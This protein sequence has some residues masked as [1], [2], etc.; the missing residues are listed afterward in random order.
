MPMCPCGP[1]TVAL[2]E[3][4]TSQALLCPLAGDREAEEREA[5]VGAEAALGRDE[6][7]LWGSPLPPL[8]EP[9]CRLPVQATAGQAQ[10]R[11]PGVLG[12]SLPL[13]QE[14]R[15]D[16]AATGPGTQVA[17]T[18]RRVAVFTGQEPA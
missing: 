16:C 7:R 11:R 6:V 10:E 2:P 17:V 15:W 1:S 5:H 3:L 8:D 12:V 14:G 4:P 9:L 18:S 13:G